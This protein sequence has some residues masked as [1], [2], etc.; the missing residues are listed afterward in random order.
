MRDEI[1][2]G[3][4]RLRRCTSD[5]LRLSLPFRV[6]RKEG[7]KDSVVG[8]QTDREGAPGAPSFLPSPPF[9]LHFPASFLPAAL[10]VLIKIVALKLEGGLS[11]RRP[12]RDRGNSFN[13]P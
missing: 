13:G 12:H 6:G 4:K 5:P 2:L 3:T 8:V 7:R 10:S 11:V 1:G 9:K